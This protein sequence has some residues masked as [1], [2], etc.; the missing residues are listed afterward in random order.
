MCRLPR[1]TLSLFALAAAGAAPARAPTLPYELP[2]RFEAGLIY[3]LPQ[4]RQ[5]VEL[6]LFTDS[7]GGLFLSTTA[8]DLI[9]AEYDADPRADDAPLGR[10]AWPEFAEH[11]WIPAPRMPADGLPIIAMPAQLQLSDG[12]VM[13]GMLGAPWFADRCWQID[14]PAQ[15][16][17]LLANGALPTDASPAHTVKLGF[18]K[19]AKGE[20]GAHFARISAR[21]DGEPLEM[22]FDTGATL[23]LKPDAAA[24]IADGLPRRR[25]GSFITQ[26][27]AK[28]WRERHPDWLYIESGE[29]GSNADLIRVADVE[30]AGYHTGPVWFALRPDRNFHEYMSQWMDQRVDGALGGSAYARFRI[31]IDYPSETAVFESTAEPVERQPQP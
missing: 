11:A 5:G 23:V 26:T 21:I 10:A 28:R 7:G 15:S 29:F 1:F 25:A 8:A 24:T 22:L 27:V 19:N 31:S 2:T 17:R 20:H 3:V 18:L 13:N 9:G 12:E 14:Y 6:R 16:L 4:T 30:V